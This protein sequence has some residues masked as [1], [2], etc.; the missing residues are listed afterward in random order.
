M[1]GLI[2]MLVLL[3]AL[4]IPTVIYEETTQLWH[5]MKEEARFRKMLKGI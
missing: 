5:R 3:L 1:G 4:V 2:T